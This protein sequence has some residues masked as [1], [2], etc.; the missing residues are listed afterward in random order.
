M[1]KFFSKKI[2]LRSRSKML[3][4]LINHTRHGRGYANNVKLYNLPIPAE[5]EE[6]AYQLIEVQDTY[7]IL[8]TIQFDWNT[9]NAPYE[10]EWEGRTS[11]HLVL[12][13]AENPSGDTAIVDLQDTCRIVME[14]DL[15]CDYIL[16]TFLELCKRAEIKEETIQVPEKIQYLVFPEE[17]TDEN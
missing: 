11:G 12:Y 5:Y 7:E 16:D 8:Q 13:G 4:F 1:E 6:K 2:D 9:E 17:E 10:V 15:L 14:F 3:E